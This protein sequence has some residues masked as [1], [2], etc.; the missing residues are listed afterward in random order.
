[1]MLDLNFFF[2]FSGWIFLLDVMSS[3][4]LDMTA[5]AREVSTSS[6]AAVGLQVKQSEFGCQMVEE[7]ETNLHDLV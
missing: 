2:R 3:D 7:G 4:Q 1:M 5:R 6:T